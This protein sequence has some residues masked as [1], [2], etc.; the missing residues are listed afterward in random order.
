MVPDVLS[1]EGVSQQVI[2]FES[3]F[4]MKADINAAEIRQHMDKLFSALSKPDESL[5]PSLMEEERT[6]NIFAFSSG[7]KELTLTVGDPS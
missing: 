6:Q 4:G 1:P 3:M 2:D 5:V 7:L